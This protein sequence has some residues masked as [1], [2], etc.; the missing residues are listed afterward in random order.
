MKQLHI[1]MDGGFGSSGKGLLAGV[2]AKEKCID[3]ICTGFGPNS[4]HTFIDRSGRTWI[5]TML[6]N[7]IVGSH[8]KRI[9]IGP[10]SVINPDNLQKKWWLQRIFQ[11]KEEVV[12]VKVV[13]TNPYIYSDHERFI[14]VIK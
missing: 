3:T 6:A 8:V 7:G 4:G 5:H 12:D 2:I 10:G 13:E 9:L 14:K 1:I 11:K